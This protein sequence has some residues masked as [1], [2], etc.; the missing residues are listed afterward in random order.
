MR[1]RTPRTAVGATWRT[2][3]RSTENEWPPTPSALHSIGATAFASVDP[4]RVCR[5][6]R[7]RSV[8]WDRG[9][10]RRDDRQ[11]QADGAEHDRIIQIADRPLSYN[12]VQRDAQGE[13][14]DEARGDGQ[15]RRLHRSANDAPAT[16]P[17]A[18]R[19]GE[20]H[21]RDAERLQFVEQPDQ[22]LSGCGRADRGAT[23][24][25]RRIGAASRPAAASL[26]PAVGPLRR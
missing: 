6:N 19:I 7:G 24:Q 23:G 8:R 20:A 14:S 11:Q 17:S 26:A 1:T 4:K 2:W 3:P 18:I 12:L 15:D 16:A 25:R 21:E 10:Y 13:T 22:V 5:L 9:G